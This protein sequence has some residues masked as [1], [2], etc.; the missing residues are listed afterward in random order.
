[1]IR[2]KNHFLQIINN[3]FVSKVVRFGIHIDGNIS[4][5]NLNLSS[6]YSN[7]HAPTNDYLELLYLLLKLGCR[8][9]IIVDLGCGS[10]GR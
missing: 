3:Y 1:M 4:L 2:N 9:K 8:K 7:E 5:K 10:G 6:K